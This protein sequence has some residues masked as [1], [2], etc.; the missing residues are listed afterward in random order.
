VS[1]A[2]TE[3]WSP[4]PSTGTCTRASPPGKNL[5]ATS[6][7]LARRRFDR[8]RTIVFRASPAPVPAPGCTSATPPSTEGVAR[9]W[10]G[11]PAAA[12]AV[13]CADG[14]SMGGSGASNS[15]AGIAL[16]AAAAAEDLVTAM[17]AVVEAAGLGVAFVPKENPS[18]SRESLPPTDRFFF[19][20]GFSASLVPPT[21]APRVLVWSPRAVRA[22][23]P[24]FRPRVRILELGPPPL[25]RARP[26][27]SP[28]RPAVLPLDEHVGPSSDRSCII[29]SNSL[30]SSTLI[31]WDWRLVWGVAIDV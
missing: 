15:G 31:L 28:M 9:G 17:A 20:C 23:V 5:G 24:L 19:V 10:S 27:L 21:L 1:A 14:C 30:S 18:P 6:G 29:F 25:S 12:V 22:V 16:A 11:A 3:I 4:P 7:R 8:L 26:R 2:E 13:A